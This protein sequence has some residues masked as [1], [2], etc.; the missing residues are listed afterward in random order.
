MYMDQRGGCCKAAS[1]RTSR[2][3]TDDREPRLE[4]SRRA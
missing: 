2:V 3:E 1:L 4:L